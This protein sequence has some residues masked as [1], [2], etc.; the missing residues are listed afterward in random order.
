MRNLPTPATLSN[1]E[2]GRY[3]Y[4]CLSDPEGIP[5]SWQEE[6]LKRFTY[7]Y[8]RAHAQNSRAPSHA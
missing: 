8:E 4:L 1:E 3:A 5:L 7:L 2:L 6:L